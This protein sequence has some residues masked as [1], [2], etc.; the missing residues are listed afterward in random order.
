MP[1]TLESG[2]ENGAGF[3]SNDNEKESGSFIY[4]TVEYCRNNERK[5]KE[6]I[7]NYS[8]GLICLGVTSGVLYRLGQSLDIISK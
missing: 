1:R 2:F 3:P 5:V 7:A 4:R 6:K 8:L